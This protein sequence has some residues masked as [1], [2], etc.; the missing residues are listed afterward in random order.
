MLYSVVLLAGTFSLMIPARL[1]VFEEGMI[2]SCPIY[3][4]DP[5]I[6]VKLDCEFTKLD[7]LARKSSDNAMSMQRHDAACFVTDSPPIS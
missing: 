4:P 2:E 5:T 6:R 1:L 7:D 3:I